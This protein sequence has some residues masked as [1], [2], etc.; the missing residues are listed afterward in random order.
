MS[1]VEV[2]QGE[3][4][5]A[6][7]RAVG[8]SVA[9]LQTFVEPKLPFIDYE[10]GRVNFVVSNPNEMYKGAEWLVKYGIR[11]KNSF[12]LASG[13]YRDVWF[14]R[15]ELKNRLGYSYVV[16]STENA[17]DSGDRDASIVEVTEMGVFDQ[18]HHLILYSTFPPVEYRS[19]EHHFSV[20][21]FVRNSALPQVKAGES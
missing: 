16:N 6:V 19:D 17:F 3:E 12:Y 15:V 18:N 5:C 21:L 2:P 1:E 13:A 9:N 7:H 8:Y 4:Y 10:S 20:S 14:S 11:L